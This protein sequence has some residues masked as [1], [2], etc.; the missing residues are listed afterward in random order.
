MR[1]HVSFIKNN[2]CIYFMLTHHFLKI[3]IKKNF[4][5]ARNSINVIL[6]ILKKNLLHRF[7]DFLGKYWRNIVA[8]YK[9][10][11][12]FYLSNNKINFF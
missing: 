4:S 12:Y 3:K 6:K 5:E 10:R 7:I 2:I 1:H 8:D 11:F 9:R